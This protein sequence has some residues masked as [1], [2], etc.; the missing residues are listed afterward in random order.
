MQ[1]FKVLLLF[2]FFLPSNVHGENWL[3][4]HFISIFYPFCMAHDT[5]EPEYL[6]FESIYVE[7]I[8]KDDLC[9]K[10]NLE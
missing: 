5:E 6:V 7:R 10:I 3:S 4:S 8:A 2:S 9:F 1:T